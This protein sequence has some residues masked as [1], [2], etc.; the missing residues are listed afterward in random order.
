MSVAPK[1]MAWIQYCMLFPADEKKFVRYLN[2]FLHT[3]KRRSQ[4]GEGSNCLYFGKKNRPLISGLHSEISG[5]PDQKQDE[6]RDQL[7]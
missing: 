5:Q 3:A 7:L 2:Q 6:C 1:L 4:L